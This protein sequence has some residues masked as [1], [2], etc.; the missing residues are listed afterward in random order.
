MTVTNST[1]LRIRY[2]GNGSTDLFA[3]P[4]VTGTRTT[5]NSEV[6]VEV[7]NELKVLSTDYD[8]TGTDVDFS[9][10]T[11]PASGAVIDIYLR[12]PLTQTTNYQT[13]AALGLQRLVR[14]E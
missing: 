7:D 10:Y 11:T 3:I 12:F 4:A 5:A 13:G 9:S 1:D 8:I 6:Y 14:R 2:I